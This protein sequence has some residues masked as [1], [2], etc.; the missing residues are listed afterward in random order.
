[1][2]VQTERQCKLFAI[3]RGTAYLKAS[4]GGLTEQLEL[5]SCSPKKQSE[6]KK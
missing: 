2:I 4:E 5:E 3:I 6:E 1:M